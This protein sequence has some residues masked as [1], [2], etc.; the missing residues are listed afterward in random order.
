M[1]R[2]VRDTNTAIFKF[3]LQ[4]GKESREVFFYE[5]G[6]YSCTDADWLNYWKVDEA[7]FWYS[8]DDRPAPLKWKLAE[9][10][11]SN[12]QFLTKFYEAYTKWAAET[13]ILV[14]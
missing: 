14:E 13:A 3:A 1:N 4:E 10:I 5:D 6:R 8:W 7:G 11:D 9:T 2:E 12:E